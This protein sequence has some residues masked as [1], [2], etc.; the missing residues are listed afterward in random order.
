MSI[1]IVPSRSGKHWCAMLFPNGSKDSGQIN[2][3][4]LNTKK[5]GLHS[6]QLFKVIWSEID[7]FCPIE[8]W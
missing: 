5:F 1:T 4:H 6:E 3:L 7:S 8:M 2:R